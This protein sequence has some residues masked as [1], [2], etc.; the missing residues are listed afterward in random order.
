MYIFYIF[1]IYILIKRIY[2]FTC[3]ERKIDNILQK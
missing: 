2:L 1:I 3:E